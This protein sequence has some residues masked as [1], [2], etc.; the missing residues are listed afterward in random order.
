MRI[1]ERKKTDWGQGLVNEFPKVMCTQDHI[2][3]QSCAAYI[4]CTD[5]TRLNSGTIN[6]DFIVQGKRRKV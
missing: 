2:P 5:K 6:E 4:L 3:G 1:R